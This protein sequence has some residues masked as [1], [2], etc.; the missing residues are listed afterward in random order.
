MLSII[1]NIFDLNKSVLSGAMDA[2]VVR[3]KDGS[4]KSSNFYVR[5]GSL[6]IMKS[7]EKIVTI[8]VN[9]KEIP[10]KMKLSSKGDAYFIESIVEKEE[11]N[12]KK[13]SKNKL[14]NLDESVD[15]IKQQRSSSI[16]VISRHKN[17]NKEM[18]FYDFNTEILNILK[19]DIK[20]QGRRS[21]AHKMK[22]SEVLTNLKKDKLKI[23]NDEIP[24]EANETKIKNYN[25]NPKDSLIKRNSYY[26]NEESNLVSQPSIEISNCLV[27]ILENT[28]N[29]EKIF[30]KLL[31]SQEL[32][33]SDPFKYLEDNNIVMKIDN[34][35]YPIK[36][37]QFF[38]MHK[39][40][41]GCEPSVESLSKF[42]VLNNTGVFGALRKKKIIPIIDINDYKTQKQ[43]I[44]Y[45]SRLKIN[46]QR[47]SINRKTLCPTSEMISQFNLQPG[48]NNITF[49]C[50]SRIT[51]TKVLHCEVHLWDYNDKIVISDVDGTITKSD[52]LG[53]IMP[54]FGK[55]WTHEG[56]SSLFNQISNNNYKILYLTARALCQSE[57][58]KNYL[59][60]INQ[61]K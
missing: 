47:N 32:F 16:P 37:G 15:S 2:I 24:D 18:D 30:N 43:D 36:A 52:V 53:Q 8:H 39:L 46:T 17:L 48:K 56:V 5:F 26:E 40:L 45:I 6:K 41:Y 54:M 7:K 3:Q 58:T 9:A 42:L 34:K 61:S 50:H 11:H 13:N 51:G 4:F 59:R 27:E 60:S 21:N 12:D 1:S 22:S 19:E 35:I 10:V 49:T 31:I 20:L 57:T 55:D 38:I 44:D 33:S 25:F 28:T 14:F 29:C 23:E